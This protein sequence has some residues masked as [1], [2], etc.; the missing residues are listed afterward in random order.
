MYLLLGSRLLQLGI[1][2]STVWSYRVQAIIVGCVLHLCAFKMHLFL[3]IW[4]VLT[5]VRDKVG[6]LATPTESLWTLQLNLSRVESSNQIYFRLEDST[7][8]D[9]FQVG[10]F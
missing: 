4:L 5:H 7:Q 8:P 1:W 6:D 9:I 2:Y 10:G 3:C